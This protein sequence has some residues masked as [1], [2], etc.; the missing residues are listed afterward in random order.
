MK[1]SR[2]ITLSVLGL[3]ALVGGY[4]GWRYMEGHPST[5]DAYLDADVVRIG[6]QVTGAVAQVP[7]QSHQEV[8]RGDL[9]FEIDPAPFR[10]AVERAQI[11]LEQ[12]SDAV[13]ATEAGLGAARALVTQREA[14][15][16]DARRNAERVLALVAK[17]TVPAS[18]GDDARASITTAEAQLDAARAQLE[19]A[20]RNL[21]LT[22]EKNAQLR[23]AEAALA[24]A[25]LQ[26]SYTRV[27]APTDGVLGEVN[28]RPGTIV[29]AG[30]PLFPLV[31]T[32][33]WWVNANFKETD[34]GRIRDGQKARIRVDM[35]PDLELTGVVQTL[36]P[37]SGAAFSLLP[38]ENATG[39]WVKVTQR[40]PVRIAVNGGMDAAH[41][42]RLGASCS[43]TVDA[44]ER[45]AAQP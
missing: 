34:L 38:P 22:G 25:Q 35:Y 15:L 12:T 23:A 31:E 7:V 16:V 29:T 9:L 21:G 1:T 20:R 2:N 40:F 19:Q 10:I 33:R 44:T 14:E 6:P 45:G 8:R 4:L 18:Q 27:T 36:S 13:G 43:V 41:P 37:A 28:L 39:N 26:L 11:Q 5:D 42:L 24:E 3:I 30:T 32:G 17:G